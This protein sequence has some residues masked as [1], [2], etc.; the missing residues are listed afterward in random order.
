MKFNPNMDYGHL[1]FLQVNFTLIYQTKIQIL[2]QLQFYGLITRWQENYFWAI[3]TTFEANII[4]WGSWGN[5][6]N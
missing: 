5:G 4:F 2:L 3:L 1:V 6:K